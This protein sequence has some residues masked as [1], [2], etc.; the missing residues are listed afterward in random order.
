VSAA[1]VVLRGGRREW[2]A[3][4]ATRQ[5][6]AEDVWCAWATGVL[7]KEQLKVQ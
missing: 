3:R 4:L 2:C 7:G 6:A 5:W 1:A